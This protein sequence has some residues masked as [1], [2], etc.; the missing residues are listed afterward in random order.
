MYSNFCIRLCTQCS[1][2]ITE[3]LTMRWN[4]WKTMQSIWLKATTEKQQWGV[5][6]NLKV[7]RPGLRFVFPVCSMVDWYER[8]DSDW[9]IVLGL[10]WMSACV[11]PGA[12]SRWQKCPGKIHH[13]NKRLDV[14]R[15][16]RV[17]LPS[18]TIKWHVWRVSNCSND[19]F[20][21]RELNVTYDYDDD[22][23]GIEEMK[24]KGCEAEMLW[25]CITK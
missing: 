8:G 18:R 5:L 2:E 16:R 25:I 20:C 1:W 7:P 17:L 3:K 9:K 10:Q 22:S 14:N 21:C 23:K 4:I 11:I 13:K 6:K 12:A 24:K 19:V 15:K